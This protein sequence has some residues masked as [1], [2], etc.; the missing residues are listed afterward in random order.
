MQNKKKILCCIFNYAPH[1][2]ESIY[3]KIDEQIPTHF[4]FGNRLLNNEQIKKLD[5]SR[6][7]GFQRELNVTCLKIGR[8]RFENTRGWLQLALNPK[9]KQYLITP[10]QFAINQ[11]FFLLLCFVLRKD[12]YVWTHGLNTKKMSR[13]ALWLYKVYDRFVHGSF[14]Y[15]N[16]ARTIM[17]QLGFNPKKLYVIY[18]SLNYE[19][20]LKLRNMTFDNPYTS[21][22]I[23]NYPVLLFIGRL[24]AVKKLYMISQAVSILK[25]KD[26]NL[27]VVFIGDGPEFVNIQN[28]VGDKERFW[29]TGAMYNEN[30]IA[31]YLY[32]AD[33]CISPGNVGLTS[34][35][36][37]SYGLPVITNDNFETQM[38]EYEAIEQGRTGDFFK[39]NDVEDLAEK[40][41]AWLNNNPDRNIVRNKCYEVIDS[42][43]NPNYQVSLIKTILNH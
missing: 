11:W 33:I 37:L 12:V 7:A 14:L 10:N 16:H 30:E 32:Y 39:E 28:S 21:H 20:S 3:Q 8:A 41:K 26:V 9:Y 35:H 15:G 13:K 1:Y 40:I 24:T 17:S 4:Y 2:R 42:K 6:L 25:E 34:I 5:Y 38:P 27:N 43:Y 36:A 18:N 31:R 23:N 19:S 22:F 29:F